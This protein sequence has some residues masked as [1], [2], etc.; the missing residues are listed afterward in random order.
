MNN[1]VDKMMLLAFYLFE[2]PVSEW[3]LYLWENVW[4]IFFIYW[5]L[6]T[7]DFCSKL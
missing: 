6:D 1:P 5:S 7:G 4:L 2:N 3:Y